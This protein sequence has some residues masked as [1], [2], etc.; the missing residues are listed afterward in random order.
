MRLADRVPSAQPW[1]ASPRLPGPRGK[2]MLGAK[3]TSFLK[4]VWG[5]DNHSLSYF[6]GFQENQVQ[7]KAGKYFV[8]RQ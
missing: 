3:G 1:W 8:I 2:A 6:S 4:S 7:Q 5:H